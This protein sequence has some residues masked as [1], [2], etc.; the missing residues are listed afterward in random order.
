MLPVYATREVTGLTALGV[1]AATI[2]SSAAEYTAPD[3]GLFAT[4]PRLAVQPTSGRRRR[5][6]ASHAWTATSRVRPSGPQRHVE[7][8][9]PLAR[10]SHESRYPHTHNAS[11]QHR[12]GASAHAVLTR[13]RIV[14]PTRVDH[15]A[16]AGPEYFD[17]GPDQNVG[18]GCGA[19]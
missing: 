8:R 17:Q 14:G 6:C 13:Q 12:R 18:D 5:R 9:L 1:A 7:P 3:V 11:R 16:D 15:L 4:D 10:G 2:W 19:E